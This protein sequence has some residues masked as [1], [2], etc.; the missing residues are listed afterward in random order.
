[1]IGN[2]LPLLLGHAGRRSPNRKQHLQTRQIGAARRVLL[3]LFP[4][5][6][7]KVG[8]RSAAVLVDES[9]EAVASLYVGRG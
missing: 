8:S 7:R 4:C 1:M 5:G 2:V 9:S 3:R 6:V